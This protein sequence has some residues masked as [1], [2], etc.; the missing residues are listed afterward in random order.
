MAIAWIPVLV[1]A[2]IWGATLSSALGGILGG[3]RIIQAISQDRIVPGF[4]GKGQGKN[5]EPRNA[6]IFTFIIAEL[7][8]L[9]GDLNVIAGVVTMFYLTA[10]G[11]INSTDTAA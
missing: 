11:F 8:V 2:G 6:L 10:Y 9:V 3:P 5:N 7:G 4:L 1:I